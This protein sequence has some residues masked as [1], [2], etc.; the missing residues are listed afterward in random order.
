M[1]LELLNVFSIQEPEITRDLINSGVLVNV[2]S[3]DFN[4]RKR[5]HTWEVRI[6]QQAL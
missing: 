1:C 5:Y 4:T 3:I 2:I 6:Y